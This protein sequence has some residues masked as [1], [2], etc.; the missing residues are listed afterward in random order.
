MKTTLRVFSG[1]FRLRIAA[2]ATTS[3]AVALAGGTIRLDQITDLVADRAAVERVYY[4]H[5]LGTKPPFEKA[6]PAAEIERLVRAGLHKE[7]ILAR[8]Y[9]VEISNSQLETEVKRINQET[10]SPEML[11]EIKRALGND[12]ARFARS[13]TRPVVVERELRRRFE[14]DDSLH[15]ADRQQADAIRRKILTAPQSDLSKNLAKT[16]KETKVGTVNEV[17]WQLGSRPAAECSQATSDPIGSPLPVKARS[18]KYSLEATAQFARVLTPLDTTNET[19]QRFYFEDL[20]AELKTVLRAQLQK[21]GDISAV[22]ETPTAF[23]LFVA[24]ERTPSILSA[25]LFSIPKRSFEQWLA[26]QKE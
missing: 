14:N 25:A 16:L 13:V 5:R 24:K 2:W 17:T 4:D 9:Q 1:S 12:P 6:L 11:L 8:V 15:G 18:A 10:R 20:S 22:I 26:E 7:S 3:F 19:D 23:L 21:P